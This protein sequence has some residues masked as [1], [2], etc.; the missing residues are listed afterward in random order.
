MPSYDQI[1]ARE[2]EEARR[3][4][5][6]E[7]PRKRYAENEAEA[8]ANQAV[9]GPTYNKSV[10][11]EKL[12]AGNTESM[13]K[14]EIRAK[15]AELDS[16]NAKLKTIGPTSWKKKPSM[17]DLSGLVGISNAYAKGGSVKSKASKRADGCCVRGK[18]RA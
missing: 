18:T 16:L 17:P 13:S 7:N 11:I 9:F 15:K 14:E 1:K 8:T 3:K 4:D 6:T 5:Q 2:K 10:A 12:L